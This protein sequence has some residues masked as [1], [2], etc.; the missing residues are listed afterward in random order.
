MGIL[1]G[2]GK[3]EKFKIDNYNTLFLKSAIKKSTLLVE[4]QHTIKTELN[5]I[6]TL[7]AIGGRVGSKK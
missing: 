7:K 5:E 4:L 3:I 1:Q 6:L 2:R